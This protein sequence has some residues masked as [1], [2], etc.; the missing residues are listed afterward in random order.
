MKQSRHR[1]GFTLVTAS[2]VAWSTAG[3]FTRLIPSDSWTLLAWRG[4]FGAL[5]LA[6][7]LMVMP[8][9]GTWRSL[10]NLGWLGWLFVL[11]SSAGMIFFLTALR[12]TTVAHVAVIYA[13]VPFIAAGLGWLVMREKPTAGAVASSLI[14]LAGVT[15]MV[16]FGHD[17]GLSGDLLALGMTFTMAVAMV[18]ARHFPEMPFLQASCLSALLSGLISLP[19]GEPLNVSGHDFILIT[20][21]G[22]TTFAVGLPLFTLGA[23]L[24]P[25][26]ETALIGSLE[27][28]LAPLWVWLMFKETP[29]A[30]TLIGGSIVLAAVGM[31]LIWATRSRVRASRAGA[32]VLLGRVVQ[33]P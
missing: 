19:F 27:A 12:A 20:L 23:R 13:T 2:A 8:Q 28:P 32:A 21:F 16:G 5:G 4:I 17:G 7:V 11:Q 25:P 33:D 6:L 26:I 10:R 22:L 3:L 31:H 29:G 1:L 14:A 9:Q 18:V 30:S 24:L 15:V